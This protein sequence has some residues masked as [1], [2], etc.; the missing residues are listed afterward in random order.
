MGTA[1]LFEDF[2]RLATAKD[3][4]ATRF[5][6]DLED[7]KLK[8][9]EQGYGAGWEDAVKAQTATGRHVAEAMVDAINQSQ[10]TRDDAIK[11]LSELIESL[12]C[13]VVEKTL[14]KAAHAAFCEKIL[15]L[16]N[17]TVGRFGQAPISVRAC[18]S[19]VGALKE[20]VADCLPPGS[21]VTAEHDLAED[22]VRI[23]VQTEEISADLPRLFNEL[24]TVTQAFLTSAK[25]NK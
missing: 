13:Q 17:E 12:F 6:E 25:E 24:E 2:S 3:P 5:E 23:A 20:L 1:L 9:F 16:V 15:D 21:T 4:V 8:S 7:Q 14:P 10:M 22:Q 18:S 11:S 19:Q